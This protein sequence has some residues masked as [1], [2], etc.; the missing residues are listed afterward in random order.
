[1][2]GE[3]RISL[4][5]QSIDKTAADVVQL[6]REKRLKIATAESC[7]GGLVSGALTS[8]SGSSEV[9]SLGICTY[10]NEQKMKQLSVPADVLES[11]GAV[12]HQTARCMAKG[13]RLAADSDIGISTTGT[14]GP[15]GGTEENPVGTVYIGIS[16]P[17][18]IE[19]VPIFTDS[20]GCP[21]AAREYVRLTAV[22]SVLELIL[23]LINA[24]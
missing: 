24:K 8:V 14:A 21:E 5:R 23:E 10:S 7:T 18:G 6:L 2:T 19:S 13:V 17:A 4:L 22:L 15:A 12:S 16:T 1:M 11:Y 9:F 3:E 20:N